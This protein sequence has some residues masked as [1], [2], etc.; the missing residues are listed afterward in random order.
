MATGTSRKKITN[1]RPKANCRIQVLRIYQ[2]K[3]HC[4]Q[5]G[6]TVKRSHREYPVN[7]REIHY[8]PRI[9]DR[10]HQKG[11]A[12]SRG[13][14]KRNQ[15]E[16]RRTANR[17]VLPPQRPINKI[18]PIAIQGLNSRTGRTA[19]NSS[20]PAKYGPH[21]VY[22]T[23]RRSEDIILAYNENSPGGKGKKVQTVF[24]RR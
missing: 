15:E 12:I 20:Q 19:I 22:Q 2:N 1:S 18:R 23:Y 14:R 16:I 17:M 24:S 3:T 10:R 9:D 6:N 4:G 11:H 21:W 7:G 5:T 8:G 13:D